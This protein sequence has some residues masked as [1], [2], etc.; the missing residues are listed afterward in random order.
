[1]TQEW[2]AWLA[3][4]LEGEGCI[5]IIGRG[6][7]LTGTTTDKDVAERA[8]ELAGGRIYSCQRP[9]RKLRYDWRVTK[10]DEVLALLLQ[11]E[12]WF[13]ER[14][15][16]RAREAIEHLEAHPAIVLDTPEHG[17]VARYRS[18]RF[19]CRC[20][21]CRSANARQRRAERARA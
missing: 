17:T 6:A 20:S 21:D 14:R 11:L 10:R 19:R 1:M 5:E 7:R 4:W 2:I 9:D 12:P 13:G 3:G 15:Q 8:R 16:A 18:H